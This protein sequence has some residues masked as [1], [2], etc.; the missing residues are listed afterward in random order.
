MAPPRI[1]AY[2]FGEMVVDGISHQQD[3]II[4]PDSVRDSWWRTRGHEVNLEDLTEILERTDITALV[5][6]QGDPG[7]MKMKPEALSAV[8]AKGWEI[9]V[10]PTTQ[11]WKTY[12]ALSSSQ[13]SI[14]AF[15][16]TC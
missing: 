4:F 6:G 5:I 1:N 7:L 15:H 12:N 13:P 2:R 10:E 8:K 9:I 11:A 3:L 14:G 16:L